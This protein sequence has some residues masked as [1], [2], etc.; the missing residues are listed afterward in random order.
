MT[1]ITLSIEMRNIVK[2]QIKVSL[3]NYRCGTF[4][5]YLFF[6]RRLG[7]RMTENYRGQ[8]RA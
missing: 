1:L 8:K 7:G 2:K 6:V 5:S 3:K 4:Y